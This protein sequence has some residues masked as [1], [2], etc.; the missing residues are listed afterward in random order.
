MLWKRNYFW[1]YA[2]G[3]F[4]VVI[5]LCFLSDL[6]PE[7]HIQLLFQCY[8]NCDILHVHAEVLHFSF[9]ALAKVAKLFLFQSYFS[10]KFLT[11]ALC[12][13]DFLPCSIKIH[14]K[15]C[16]RAHLILKCSPSFSPQCKQQLSIV[17][18]INKVSAHL[19]HSFTLT[20]PISL[21]YNTYSFYLAWYEMGYHWKTI[22]IKMIVHQNKKN[23][24][25]SLSP[26]PHLC[27]TSQRQNTNIYL[28]MSGSQ[29]FHTLL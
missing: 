28:T 16:N 29:N 17:L 5:V 23:D 22:C 6:L 11:H 1:L 21:W 4:R 27:K 10:T 3:H 20:N 15:T 12:K 14:P 25:Y 9:A 18:E 8:E 2:K 13:F 24:V 7:R 19:L 26:L